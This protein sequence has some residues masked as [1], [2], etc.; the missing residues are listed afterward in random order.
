MEVL[1]VFPGLLLSVLGEQTLYDDDSDDNTNLDG[2]RM[3]FQFY[4]GSF[5]SEMVQA[6]EEFSVWVSLHPS[7]GA[8]QRAAAVHCICCQDFT[9]TEDCEFL[10]KLVS[11]ADDIAVAVLNIQGDFSSLEQRV[12]PTIS[13]DEEVWERLD[14]WLRSPVYRSATSCSLHM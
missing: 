11:L 6:S 8:M 13:T 12:C 10:Q 5:V 14:D 3:E 4:M 2:L 1:P 7:R 9:G